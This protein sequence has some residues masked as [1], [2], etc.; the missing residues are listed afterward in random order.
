MIIKDIN[1]VKLYYLY[2]DK[3]TT[4]Q[5]GILLR[6]TSN[7]KFHLD[8]QIVRQLM[9]KVTK[10]YPTEELLD[11]HLQNLYSANL[12]TLRDNLGNFS[13]INF[14]SKFI[15]DEY[16]LDDTKIFKEIVKLYNE[17]FT[18]PSFYIDGKLNFGI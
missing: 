3:F 11:S 9:T 4:S 12:S 2:V 5:F 15:N 16:V 14:T 7:R 10:T 6:T 17:I 13:I 8:D 1:G 18:V